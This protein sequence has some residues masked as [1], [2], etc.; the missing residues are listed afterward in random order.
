MLNDVSIDRVACGRCPLNEDRPGQQEAWSSK[1]KRNASLLQ[2][3]IGSQRETR[4]WQ[5]PSD[6]ND[7]DIRLCS[8]KLEINI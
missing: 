4:A 1:S 5:A 8:L 6:R 3:A 7:R 2:S